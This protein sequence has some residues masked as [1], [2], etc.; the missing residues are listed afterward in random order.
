MDAVG[1]R[2]LRQRASEL[3]RRVE[4]GDEV[5]ITVAGR[6]S[7]RLVAVAPR[8]WRQWD[9]VAELF[10]GPADTAWEHDRGR[11][12]HDLRDPWATR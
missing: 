1:L 11:L 4:A 9:E 3:V 2:E 6:P 5:T 12:D 8:A 7:A 10:T